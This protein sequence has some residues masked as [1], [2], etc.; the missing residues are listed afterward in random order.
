MWSIDDAIYR[1]VRQYQ[2]RGERVPSDNLTQI[3]SLNRRAKWPAWSFYSRT[4]C[5]SIDL[6]E[7]LLSN[8]SKR[9][10]EGHLLVILVIQSS[11]AQTLLPLVLQYVYDCGDRK[12]AQVDKLKARNERFALC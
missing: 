1:N 12:V 8:L 4:A 9:K 10:H 2:G 3:H 5:N 11:L 6:S 7:P